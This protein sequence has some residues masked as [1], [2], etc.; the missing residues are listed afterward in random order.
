VMILGMMTPWGIPCR[1]GGGEANA[2]ASGGRKRG[3]EKGNETRRAK[4][5]P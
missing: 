3:D 5:G 1:E 2:G 4:T